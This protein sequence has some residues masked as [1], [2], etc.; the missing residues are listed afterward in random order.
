M[1]YR[2]LDRPPRNA[3]VGAGERL[4]LGHSSVRLRRQGRPPQVA[5]MGAGARVPLGPR[6][7]ARDG[8]PE[9]PPCS[10]LVVGRWHLPRVMGRGRVAGH[11]RGHCHCRRRRRRRRRRCRRR[12]RGFTIFA[13][14]G[15]LHPKDGPRRTPWGLSGATASGPQKRRAP[16]PARVGKRGEMAH[17]SFFTHVVLPLPRQRPVHCLSPAPA[18]L[19][20]PAS[21]RGE[22][23]SR[24]DVCVKFT[25]A[26]LRARFELRGGGPGGRLNVLEADNSARSAGP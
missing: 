24:R 22:A 9:R 10:A 26:G 12:C 5:A 3:A 19:R 8:Y 23:A 21:F 16:M 2:R 7:G 4:P 18:A 25:P 15:R 6:K 17:T 20:G 13:P 11:C 14:C 1:P